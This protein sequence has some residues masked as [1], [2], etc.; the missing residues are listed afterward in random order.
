MS[1]STVGSIALPILLGSLL[2]LFCIG[3]LVAQ[4]YIYPISFPNDRWPL[5]CLVYFLLV[6][7]LIEIYLTISDINFWFSTSFGNEVALG[8]RRYSQY[9]TSISGALVGTVAQLF[10]VYRITRIRHDM[11][12]LCVPIV[13]VAIT[14]FAAGF[15]VGLK[16]FIEDDAPETFDINDIDGLHDRVHSVLFY[17]WLVGGAVADILIAVIMTILLRRTASHNAT[18]AIARKIIY[19]VFETNLSSAAA[20]VITVILF[21]ALPD[22]LYY[23]ILEVPL[24]GIY[25]NTLLATFNNRAIILHQRRIEASRHNTYVNETIEIRPR[26]LTVVQRFHRTHSSLSVIPEIESGAAVQYGSDSGS[27]ESLSSVE[28]MSFAPPNE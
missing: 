3:T 1:S 15:G 14:G 27:S 25:A 20:V 22:N 9:Y 2:S 11:W 21:V 5:K 13:I 12:P 17:L 26:T 28:T 8:D 16:S 4:V 24:S 18:H 23:L 19:M 6:A 10:F 7:M